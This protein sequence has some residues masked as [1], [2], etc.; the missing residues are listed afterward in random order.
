[1]HGGDG[2]HEE[3]HGTRKARKTWPKLH[4]GLDPEIGEVVA[5][6]LT[7]EHVGDETALPDLLNDVDVSR[8]LSDG[9]YDGQGVANSLESRFGPG[10]EVIIP[11]PKEAVHSKNAK[12]NHHIDVIARNARKRWQTKT[13][14]NERS[15]VEAQIGR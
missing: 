5:S 7:T 4:I 3:K 1:M 12:R 14:Y 15:R 2:W 13:G 11:P 9:A 6:K 8:F 10:I